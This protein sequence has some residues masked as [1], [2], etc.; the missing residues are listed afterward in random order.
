ML[1]DEIDLPEDII[2][3]LKKVGYQKLYPP[4]KEALKKDF[5]SGKNLV[6]SIPT[7]SGK[8][9][10]AILAILKTLSEGGK[11]IYIVPLR[12]LAEEKF[13]ELKELGVDVILSTGD[14][15]SPSR[16][17]KRYKC[18]VT[19][20]EKCDSLLRHSRNFL[21][22]FNLLIADEV[23]LLQDPQRGPTL[24]I[25]LSRVKGKQLI[26]LSATIPN[27]KEISD[28]LNSEVVE[29]DWRPVK[30]DLGV[31]CDGKLHLLS[32]ELE[33]EGSPLEVLSLNVL[34][35]G[36]QALIFVN[37]RASAKST[38]RKLSNYLKKLGFHSKGL[39]FRESIYEKE[40]SEFSRREVSFHHAGLA[41]EDR[42][43]IEENFKKNKLKVLVATPT[44]AAGV[45]L[46]ARRVII[47]DYRR[48]YQN[49]GYRSIP[50]F[51][52]KQMMGR[53]GRPK[54]DDRGEAI[55]LA[56][57]EKEKDFLFEKYILSD[58]ERI[59][60]KLA[61]E[62]ILRCH[63]LALIA[64]DYVSSE[65][66]L[67][68]FFSKTFYAHQYSI[69]DVFEKIKNITQYLRD[70]EF[71]KDFQATKFGL[72]TSQLYIDPETA[73]IFRKALRDEMSDFGVLHV[74]CS[75]PDIENLYL[76]RGE[77]EVYDALAVERE[78]E[79]LIEVPDY[80]SK[81]EAYEIFLS[82][83]KTAKLIEDWLCEIPEE[84]LSKSYRVGPGDL[85][86]LRENADWL[87]Y[88]FSEIAKLFSYKTKLHRLR[89]RLKYGVK[90]ELLPLVALKG[91]GRVRARKLFDA[92]I[93]HRGHLKK[94]EFSR[95]REILG[96]KIALSA[97]REL[98]EEVLEEG[99]DE[100][101]GQLRIEDF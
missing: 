2:K 75:T 16:Y 100:K 78:G 26:A 30:L 67:E 46:P 7:A 92:G 47:R 39:R 84:E 61:Q 1:I 9:L 101:K 72:R 21:D 55:L 76:R 69:E 38:A 11:A 89:T 48:Y 27:A 99:N 18:I 54:Y 86:V 83:L 14:Y 24:E 60:S 25:I 90:E 49:L 77:F 96:G 62:P 12:A 85:Y 19:T 17:L 70:N 44:L 6:L 98:G 59:T 32:S 4:Q 88:S 95:L 10:V 23:H 13:S 91:I 35:E 68:N 8:T 37:T 66:E 87:I 58:A 93:K 64:S 15:D 5:L 3:R 97:K 57:E 50:V 94:I 73:I 81:P 53:A 79:F 36:G 63:I 40:L 56:K 74:I 51:E 43:I 82:E 20:Y 42:K 65:N 28:W 71:I 34:R 45:N 22:D 80:I 52:I 29:S 41:R 31:F 33:L